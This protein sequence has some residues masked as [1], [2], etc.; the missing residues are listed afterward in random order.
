MQHLTLVKYIPSS[1]A[2]S[3]PPITANGL[4]LK[5]GTAPSQTAH[6][7]IPDCQYVS[8]PGRFNRRADAPVAIMTES[9]VSGA[10]SSAPSRQY[11]NGRFDRSARALQSA[12]QGS[13]DAARLTNFGDGFGVNLSSEAN[14]L[15]SEQIH[16]LGSSDTVG[17]SG[18]AR[19]N[20]G[21]SRENGLR[22]SLSV[23]YKF[24]TSVVV[25][26]CPPAA[27]PLASIPWRERCFVRT[28]I[29]S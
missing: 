18:T 29:P 5:I 16:H 13:S 8:S 24:S 6:A 21:Q 12:M 2:E 7:L 3:P 10:D 26:S 9:A 28:R 22:D 27:N 11:L 23:A 4:F 19:T 17:E 14:G 20:I 1:H 25:V 15:R